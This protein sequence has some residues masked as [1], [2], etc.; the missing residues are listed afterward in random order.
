MQSRVLGGEMRRVATKG[1]GRYASQ[2]T[3]VQQ[4]AK[5]T[6]DPMLIFYGIS[7]L[8]VAQVPLGIAVGWWARGLTR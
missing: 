1:S 4:E 5:V 8:L 3:S 2:A 7:V 6:I